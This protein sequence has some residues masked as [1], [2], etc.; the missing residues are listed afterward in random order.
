MMEKGSKSNE[1]G[2]QLERAVVSV[3][4]GKRFE[5]V[6]Y[7]DWEKNK[8]KYGNELL[9]VN[10][11]FTTI[12]KH[13]GNTEFLLLS[14]R[15]NICA[16]IECKWQQVSGS[17]DEKLPYLYLNAIEAMPENTI[18]IL[19][20]GQGWKQGAI[21]WLKDAVSSKKYSNESNSSKQIFVFNLTEFFTWANN[22]FQ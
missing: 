21:Q 7:R 19:I 11:P 18:I 12:Y 8:E 14:E 15:Y 6:K 22:T 1:T 5:I 17:V 16:R 9:L 20:D 3:F 10:V 2:N 13:N 4:R